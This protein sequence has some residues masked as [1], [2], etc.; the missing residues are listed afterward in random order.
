MVSGGYRIR[1]PG[2]SERSCHPDQDS[3]SLPGFATSLAAARPSLAPRW[4]PASRSRAAG[5][6]RFGGA[7]GCVLG[8]APGTRLAFGSRLGSPADVGAPEIGA[9]TVS[10]ARQPSSAGDDQRRPAVAVT[11]DEPGT[12]R[13][14][15]NQRA[16]TASKMGSL[17]VS[18][19]GT[20]TSPSAGLVSEFRGAASSNGAE[21]SCGVPVL[22]NAASRGRTARPS[23]A[24]R[25][26]RLAGHRPPTRRGRA[27]GP[28]QI[29]IADRAARPAHPPAVTSTPPTLPWPRSAPRCHGQDPRLPRANPALAR[30]HQ[31]RRAWPAQPRPGE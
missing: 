9:S 19:G 5:A 12:S 15:L 1:A 2:I 16:S 29:S 31:N 14:P 22:P 11:P 6:D 23:R 20:M 10:A 18:A 4:N 21:A 28:R 17:R 8:M 27:G 24:G 7:T 3:S 13:L 26:A 30:R 25:P